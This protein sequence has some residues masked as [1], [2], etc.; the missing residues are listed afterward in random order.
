MSAL[1]QHSAAFGTR[2]IFVSS[3]LLTLTFF[4]RRPK[5]SK[6][7]DHHQGCRGAHEISEFGLSAG[8]DSKALF[9]RHAGERDSGGNVRR[10]R[11]WAWLYLNQGGLVRDWIKPGEAFL[12]EFDFRRDHL[13]VHF[14]LPFAI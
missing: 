12:D 1:C 8:N 3:F 2:R 10:R 4:R 7:E 13:F 9:H 6:C 11:P 14:P 5:K